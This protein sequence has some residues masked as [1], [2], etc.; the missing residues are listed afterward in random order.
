[1]PLVQ[2]SG[3]LTVYSI[4]STSYLT[5]IK[6]VNY[7]TNL[8]KAET[9][10]IKR[11]GKRRQN[12]KKSVTISTSHMS[13]LAS[14]SGLMASNLSISEFLIGAV[15]Y[16]EYLAGGTFNGSFDTREVSGPNDAFTFPQ[17][18]GKDY[19][20][21]V[22]LRIPL[23]GDPNPL[24]NLSAGIHDADMLD[25]DL[26]RV[27]F[28]ITIDGSSIL[29]PMDVEVLIIAFNERQEMLATFNLVGND[30]KTGD[31]PTTPTGTTTLLEKCFNAYNTAIPFSLTTAAGTAGVN[32]AGDVIPG[33]FS[34]GFNDSEIIMIDFEFLSRGNF[35]PTNGT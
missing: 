9:G 35:V 16:V 7:R 27:N 11:A 6:N 15:D 19:A 12:V 20:A 2:E 25:Q 18:F 5:L 23:T 1:M 13:E 14:D 29:V 22:N 30:P 32:Y 3:D 31:Y 24:R 8:T 21:T 4:A 34:F 28:G 17:H 33:P 26:S 10:S